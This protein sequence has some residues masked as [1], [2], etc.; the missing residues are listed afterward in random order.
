M[1]FTPNLDGFGEYEPDP[2]QNTFDKL[3][4]EAM[5]EKEKLKKLKK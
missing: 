5:K 2:V 1:N 4:D 3:R